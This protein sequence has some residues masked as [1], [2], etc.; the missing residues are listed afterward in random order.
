MKPGSSMFAGL[1]LLALAGC[2][3]NKKPEMPPPAPSLMVEMRAVADEEFLLADNSQAFTDSLMK[4]IR[5]TVEWKQTWETAV[6]RRPADSRPPKPAVDFSKEMIILAAAGRMKPGDAIH[7]DSIGAR[8]DLTVIVVRY[9]VGCQDL[10]T[11]AWPFEMARVPRTN[12]EV[13]WREHRY[14][15]PECQ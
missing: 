5:D 12:G 9:T 4:V 13:T 8:K 6:S 11:T 1:A 2:H 15:A 3:K 7:I 14:K 10:K